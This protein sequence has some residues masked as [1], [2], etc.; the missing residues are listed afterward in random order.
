MCTLQLLELKTK[1]KQAVSEEWRIYLIVKKYTALEEYNC[2]VA[3]FQ[4]QSSNI[5]VSAH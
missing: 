1:T 4:E 3:T 5:N 2:T